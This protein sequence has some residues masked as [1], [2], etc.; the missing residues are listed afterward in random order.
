M[1]VPCNTGKTGFGNGIEDYVIISKIL[2]YSEKLVE[3]VII[4]RNGQIEVKNMIHMWRGLK[5]L[6]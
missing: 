4:I 5:V 6:V 2:V 3:A 1:K